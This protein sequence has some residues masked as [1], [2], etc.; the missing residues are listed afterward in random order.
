MLNLHHKAIKRFSLDGNIHDDSAIARL[1]SEYIKLLVAEMRLSGY[2]PRLD[3][4]PDFTLSYNEEKRYFEF[5]I[6][7][8]GIYIGKKQSEWILGIDEIRPIYIQE[9]KSKE[10][11]RE[12]A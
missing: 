12:Q 6:S 3:I 1:K 8:Y 10:F 4:N 2:V 9:S 5:K 7:L 11:L